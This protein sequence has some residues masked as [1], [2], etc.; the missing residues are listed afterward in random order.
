M[1]TK[2]SLRL[3]KKNF[4]NSIAHKKNGGKK[5]VEGIEEKKAIL[6]QLY[7]F[8]DIHNVVYRY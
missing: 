3:M 2:V 7:F 6:E 5:H 1:R 4:F 8:L